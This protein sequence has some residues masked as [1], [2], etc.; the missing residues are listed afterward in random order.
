[1]NNNYD[2]LD[3]I[4]D[5]QGITRAEMTPTEKLAC[6]IGF[7][8]L[9]YCDEMHDF[10]SVRAKLSGD[11]RFDLRTKRFNSLLNDIN[12]FK[13]NERY[14]S[15][16]EGLGRPETY[17]KSSGNPNAHS[18][19]VS[20]QNRYNIDFIKHIKI[21]DYN[22]PVT[23][24]PQAAKLRNQDATIL[25]EAHARAVS[26]WILKNIF[27]MKPI[28]ISLIMGCAYDLNIY[29]ISQFL[30]YARD[31]HKK[32]G[33]EKAKL[34]IN[35]D[36]TMSGSKIQAIYSTLFNNY[37]TKKQ[38]GQGVLNIMGDRIKEEPVGFFETLA[39]KYDP[40]NTDGLMKTMK[41]I[42]SPTKT[43]EYP[44]NDEVV[45]LLF[46]D[47]P[48]IT[49]KFV[50]QQDVGVRLYIDRY[51][52]QTG[53]GYK[54]NSL[55]SVAQISQVITDAGGAANVDNQVAF[56]TM[57]DFLQVISFY[58]IDKTYGSS[59]DVM[60]S[61]VTGDILCGRLASILSRNVILELD[62][63]MSLKDIKDYLRSSAEGGAGINRAQLEEELKLKANL[64]KGSINNDKFS[65]IS[66]YF[67]ERD[68]E[69]LRRITERSP[70]TLAII[71]NL[72]N[73]TEESLDRVMKDL[74]QFGKK[75]KVSIR[76][77]STKVLKAKLKLVGIPLSK[78]IRGKRMKLTRKQ[79]EL[80]AE[81]FKKLQMRCQ[82]KGISLT[83][84]SKKGRK[85]KSV[86]RL[87]SDM[88]RKPK[89]KPKTKKKSKM[90]WG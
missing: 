38:C 80:R 5:R 18:Y 90:K 33:S 58:M 66:Y 41:Q 50:N 32:G 64:L 65:G 45:T 16:L 62:N 61:F 76:N 24:P 82:K 56:K 77:T 86:K 72:V 87:L 83:Y 71:S 55:A 9:I 42:L 30:N 3:F 20:I 28:P 81:A 53:L 40:A 54:D 23:S 49:Y 6:F 25:N 22:S 44:N 48:I 15:V 67:T 36:A 46:D 43:Y 39:N 60:F 68:I 74:L 63:K 17:N 79:L 52:N 47:I 69:E 11:Q 14:R 37:M 85:Y 4:C 13:K 88:K 10:M 78:V 57:G 12:A 29:T 26:E 70:E 34:N 51:F 27:M 59:S 35:V 7:R 2:L 19:L 75:K 31:N 21:D 73:D 84:V 1:M 8:T 89:T